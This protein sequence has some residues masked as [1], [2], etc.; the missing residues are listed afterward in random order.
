MGFF[1]RKQIKFGKFALNLSKSGLGA[2]F[3]LKGL[4]LSFGSKGVQLN[5]GRN[6]LYFR[7]SLN[8]KKVK[9]QAKVEEITSEEY[10]EE[11]CQEEKKKTEAK[12][13]TK[14]PEQE[15]FEFIL[16]LF[17]ACFLIAFIGLFFKF[18]LACLFGI[19]TFGARNLFINKNSDKYEIYKA[20]P[21]PQCYYIGKTKSQIEELK[22]QAEENNEKI[23]KQRQEQINK[24]KYQKQ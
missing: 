24:K 22:K 21:E 7:K 14:S 17:T 19:I 12:L 8:G 3:G 5:A 23:I 20:N 9:P 10:I 16:S 4:R 15:N 1:L 13:I 18:W 6:G 2:S 11:A